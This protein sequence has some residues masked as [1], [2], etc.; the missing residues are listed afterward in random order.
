M[1]DKELIISLIKQAEVYRIQGLLINAKEKYLE[2]LK[3]IEDH[4]SYSKDMKLI[5][6]LKNKIQTVEHTLAEID[7]APEAPE[8]SQEVQDLINKLFTFSQNKD[9]GQ[10]EGAV[11][12]A[13]FGQYE[14]AVSEFQRLIGEGILPL[15]AAKNMLKCHLT[16][17]SPDAAIDQFKKWVS[18]S[19]FSNVDL[20]SLRA[21]LENS[22]E[23][24][25]IK[26]DL[27]QVVK[28]TPGEG[29]T[30]EEEEEEEKKDLELS[31]VSVKLEKGS[32]KGELVEFDVTFQSGN[33]ISTII[34]AN[35][36]DLVDAFESGLQL[37]EIQCYSSLAVFNTTGTVSKKD[38]IPSGPKR[39][40]YTLDIK[41]DPL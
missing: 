26:A 16:L 32:R 20:N 15:M 24:E 3:M 11:A 35:E 13:K 10:I 22:L 8:L 1:S 25:G 39:G 30:K 5:N 21:F 17:S 7:Q 28:A 23:R 29:K 19:L 33:T 18:D 12:L 37:T 4:E 34:S 6:G 2:V 38:K 36:K 9:I 41:I 31:S 14:R 27:P 40:D